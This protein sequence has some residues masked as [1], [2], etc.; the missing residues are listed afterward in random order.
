MTIVVDTPAQA[1]KRRIE[2]RRAEKLGLDDVENTKRL[3]TESLDGECSD[4]ADSSSLVPSIR[5][6]KR[7]ARYEPGV[8]MTK[9]ELQKWR[10]QARRVR[11]RESAAASRQKT[12]E[13]INELEGEVSSL[14]AELAAARARIAQLEANATTTCAPQVSKMNLE[15]AVSC[16]QVSVCSPTTSP[17]ASPLP[18]PRSCSPPTFSLDD[19]TVDGPV[20]LIPSMIS[21]PTAV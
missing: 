7:Q 1:R 4:D 10:K 20:P 14:Q 2:Q 15:K 13:R 11:N 5:G 3:R 19:S 6:I 12:R 16:S 18:A 8:P 21:R 9:D 17:S